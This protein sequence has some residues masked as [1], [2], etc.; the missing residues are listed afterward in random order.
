MITGK[1]AK[2]AFEAHAN[3][4]PFDGKRVTAKLKGML[5]NA[6]VGRRFQVG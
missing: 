1:Q 3:G 6:C 4:E 5:D 2:F